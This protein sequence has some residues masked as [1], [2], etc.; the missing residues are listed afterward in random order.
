MGVVDDPP[1]L[2]GYV[3]HEENRPL[4]SPTVVRVMRV[5]VVL[6]VIGLIVPSVAGTIALQNQNAQFLCARDVSSHEFGADPVARFEVLGAAGP[7]WYC[8]AR[9][10]D[11]R[12][13]LIRSLGL[14]PG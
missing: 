4:R 9:G 10:F 7:G 13:V 12:E 1:E 8:Y 6:G 5:A 3:P 14:I 2:A 11:G